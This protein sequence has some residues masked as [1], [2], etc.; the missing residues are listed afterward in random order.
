MNPC[1]DPPPPEVPLAHA[2]LDFVICQVRFPTMFKIGKDEYVVNFQEALGTAYPLVET[3]VIQTFQ[4]LAVGGEP[5]SAQQP[6]TKTYR[7][8]SPDHPWSLTLAPDFMSLQTRQGGYSSR[9][10]FL[11]RLRQALE[12]L[13]AHIKPSHCTRLGIRYL[14][15]IKG[16]ET[17]A[18]AGT[19]FRPELLGLRDEQVLG[20]TV[21]QFLS[22]A[23]LDVPEGTL[24][25]RWGVLPANQTIDPVMIQPESQES[26]ILDLDAYREGVEPFHADQLA[27]AAK[28]LAE[29]VY[30]FFRW[31]VLPPFDAQF[32]G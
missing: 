1:I 31:S 18:K 9:T 19:F 15:R 7:F 5:P 32:R 21:R 3:Q 12:A 27:I 13:G 8:H 22:Q 25:V 14:D 16:E 17:L 30:T 26:W 6:A 29:R 28:G 24:A 20:Q 10:D 11:A 23:V 2:P 4:F